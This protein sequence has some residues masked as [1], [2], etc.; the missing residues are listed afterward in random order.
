VDN[1]WLQP[2]DNSPY[3]QLTHFTSER[4]AQFAFSPDGSQIAF[5]HGHTE[6]D[7]VLLRDLGR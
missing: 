4:I 7:A 2:L 5:E 3:R 6:S 1:L